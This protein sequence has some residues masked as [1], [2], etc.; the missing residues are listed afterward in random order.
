[1]ETEKDLTLEL[2]DDLGEIELIKCVATGIF[3]VVAVDPEEA[4][5]A[6]YYIVDKDCREL[7]SEA[8]A[9]GVPLEY[10]EGYISYRADVPED[11]RMVLEYEINRYLLKNNLPALDGDTILSIAT[12]G[13]EHNP[14]YFGDYPAPTLTPR[15]FP[16][17][18]KTLTNGVFLIE[19]DKLEK[20]LAVCQPIWECDLSEYTKEHSEQLDF[21][22]LNGISKTAGYLFFSQENACLALFELW[23]PYEKIGKSGRINVQAMMN[24]I[25][26]YHPTYATSHNLREQTGLNDC[27]GL[28]MNCLGVEV[29]LV[30]SSENMISISENTGTEY[31]LI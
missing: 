12:Y 7:S 25:W 29:D 14:E 20:V 26:Q 19:T 30:G 3:Y 23:K 8:K 2:K 28:L 15:G 21:D 22:R 24:A 4:M 13:R 1:M 5:P 9:Y 11:G 31:L 6:E 27:L 16:L 18:Y 10:H 17:R